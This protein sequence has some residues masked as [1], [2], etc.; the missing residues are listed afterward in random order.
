[1]ALNGG[2]KKLT[3]WSFTKKKEKEYLEK[4]V[5]DGKLKT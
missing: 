5:K 4:L 2:R 1:M 3:L